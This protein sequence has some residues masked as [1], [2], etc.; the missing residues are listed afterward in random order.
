MAGKT[1][2]AENDNTPHIRDVILQGI[3][4]GLALIITCVF[5]GHLGGNAYSA[6]YQ[7]KHHGDHAHGKKGD[8]GKK[9]DAK[10]A[11]TK[12]AAKAGA[13]KDGAK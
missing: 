1:A 13:K 8:H 12:D 11:D 5:I 9:A 7:A 3:F 2:K 6:S 10:K 4:G